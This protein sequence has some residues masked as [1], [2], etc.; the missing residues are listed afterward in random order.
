MDN[1]AAYRMGK[2]F[3]NYTFDIRLIYK[4]LKELKKTGHEEIKQLN[5]NRV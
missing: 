1:V 2:I 3:I 5:K 4:I